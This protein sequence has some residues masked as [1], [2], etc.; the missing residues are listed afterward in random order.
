MSNHRRQQS[1][2]MQCFVAMRIGDAETD[3]VYD[4]FIA[5]TI[6][7]VGLTPRRIDRVLHNERIDQ[8]IQKEL[9]ACHVMISDLT[10]ARPS[11]YWEAG[12]VE[13][14]GLQVVY[15]CRKDHFRQREGDDY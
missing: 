8:K 7:R 9:Q 14:R 15:T 13:G 6:R 10:F 2:S 12:F 11:V 5:P 3:A 4:R 1:L